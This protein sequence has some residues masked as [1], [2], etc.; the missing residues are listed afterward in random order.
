[1]F[2]FAEQIKKSLCL[3]ACLPACPS[4]P[5]FEFRHKIVFTKPLPVGHVVVLFFC[6][7]F[8]MSWSGI[9]RSFHKILL[10]WWMTTGPA[11]HKKCL[12]VHEFYTPQ[13]LYDCYDQDLIKA[14][15]QGSTI[16]CQT[17]FIFTFR[18]SN[19]LYGIFHIDYPYLTSHFI[20]TVDWICIH[21]TVLTQS[22]SGIM[23]VNISLEWD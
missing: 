17:G 23:W 4:V 14:E 20:W 19:I 8:F 22:V 6:R 1:M 2:L 13:H 9:P 18:S 15:R 3:P 7:Q 10:L 16:L 21:G 12:S 11:A 5:D